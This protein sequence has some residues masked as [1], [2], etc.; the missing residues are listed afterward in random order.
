MGNGNPLNPLDWVNSAQVWFRK[1][2]RSSGFRPYLI[3]LILVFTIVCVLLLFFKNIP[4]CA[5]VA[6]GLL[7]ASV[8][9][10]IVLFALKAIQDPNFARSERHIE[11]M[12]RLELEP[13]GTE[14]ETM[15]AE[16]YET[17]MRLGSAPDPVSL[18]DH[19][20]PQGSNQ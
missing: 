7:V 2:E 3:F 14:S 1:T 9:A 4:G 16:D 15:T 19:T 5:T 13:M 8:L 10:F 6:L 17:Q 20:G 11:Q 12:K 18:D